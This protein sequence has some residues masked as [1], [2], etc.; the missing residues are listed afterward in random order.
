M[1][2]AA[3]FLWLCKMAAEF[4]LYPPFHVVF[5]LL[6]VN[7]ACAYIIQRPFQGDRWCRSHW[8]VFTQVLFCPAVIAA[9]VLGG[10]N[11]PPI[12]EPDRIAS[13]FI[14]ALFW[15]SLIT[16]VFWTWRMKGIRW[17]AFSFVALQQFLFLAAFF[18]ADMAV[19]GNWL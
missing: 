8:L 2:R 17:T 13:L 18:T 4:V 19:S 16:G 10:V 3:Q 11:L 6:I 7:L 1:S 15:A 14:R 9:A 12:H 5:G